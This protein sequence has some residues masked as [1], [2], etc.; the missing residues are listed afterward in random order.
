[1]RGKNE[2]DKKRSMW[3]G[4]IN[5]EGRTKCEKKPYVGGRNRMIMKCL[6]VRYILKGRTENAKKRSMYADTGRKEGWKDG[7]QKISGV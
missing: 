5:I 3:K 1:M 2:A 7:C 4:W 6:Y